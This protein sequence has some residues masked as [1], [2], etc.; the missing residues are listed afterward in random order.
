[1]SKWSRP[2]AELVEQ[3][4]IQRRALASS[5]DR[6]D[7]GE[8]WEA[9]RLATAVYNLVHDGGRRSQSILTQLGVRAQL[10]FVSTSRENVR[11]L[12]P[13]MPLV[14]IKLGTEGVEYLPAKAEGSRPTYNSQFPNWWT[15]EIVY[16]SGDIRVSRRQL[17]FALRNKDGGSHFDPE[18]DNDGYLEMSRVGA[19]MVSLDG[20]ED[21]PLL[22]LEHATMRQISWELEETLKLLPDEFQ[23]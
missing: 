21:A 19:F 9:L 14:I 11:N 16:R 12:L 17:I 7:I 4:K 13:E 20:R 1:M 8:K 22:G 10:R 2:R 5:G 23:E 3:L 18:L 15:S 6:Y